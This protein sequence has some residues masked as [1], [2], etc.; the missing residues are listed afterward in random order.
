MIP[1]RV[2][3]DAPLTTMGGVRTLGVGHFANDDVCPVCDQPL[4][5]TPITLVF[6]GI[7]PEDRKESGWTTGGSVIVHGA[8]AGLKV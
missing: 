8:C 4:A 1:V 5:N 7:A 3:V 6:V 2:P